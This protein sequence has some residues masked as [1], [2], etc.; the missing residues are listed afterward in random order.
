MKSIKNILNLR[1]LNLLLRNS[2]VDPRIGAYF[3]IIDY[4]SKRLR[5]EI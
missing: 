5:G 4:G 2:H 1:Y 3:I